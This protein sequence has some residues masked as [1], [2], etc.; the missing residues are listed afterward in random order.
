MSDNSD[1]SFT[2]KYSPKRASQAWERDVGVS[3]SGPELLDQRDTFY[4]GGP[5]RLKLREF[6]DGTAIRETLGL[7]S[8][9]PVSHRSWVSI[10]R[11]TAF[12]CVFACSLTRLF[13]LGLT[14]AAF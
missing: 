3:A 5:R 11:I 4:T 7:N 2:D 1:N 9:S 14:N 8:S 10:G 13:L 6:S 12:A